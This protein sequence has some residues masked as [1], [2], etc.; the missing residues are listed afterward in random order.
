MSK[1]KQREQFNWNFKNETNPKFHDWL[2][3]QSNIS[4][5]LITLVLHFVDQYGINDVTDYEIS[6]QMQ[7]DLFMKE[8]FFQDISVLLENTN[9]NNINPNNNAPV[10]EVLA[11]KIEKEEN[12]EHVENVDKKKK[13]TLKVQKEP[14]DSYINKVDESAIFG[15]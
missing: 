1:Q 7:R 14:D 13:M 9:V 10:S 5:S 2:N 12:I 8:K 6:K 15:D 4:E 11:S 3:T